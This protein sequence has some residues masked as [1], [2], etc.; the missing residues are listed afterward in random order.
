M[1]KVNDYIIYKKEVCQIKDILKDY[2]HEKD[3]YQL[4]LLSDNTL[5]IKVPVDN[6]ELRNLIT[7][8]QA[9]QI[10]AKID[11]ITPIEEET[12]NLENI[13]KELLK[14]GEYSDLIKIIKTTYLRNKERLDNHK[15]TTDKDTYYFELA[16]KYL[17]E[18]FQIVLGLTYEQ[19]R[20][21]IIDKVKELSSK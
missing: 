3:Y 1:L 6:K 17:I 4:T 13:Y 19:T 2:Y 14:S 5:N 16:E 20:N 21:F 9:M 7:K 11:Q 18:E 8:D 12:K 15:K 10:I